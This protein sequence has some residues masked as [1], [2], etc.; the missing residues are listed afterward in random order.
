MKKFTHQHFRLGVFGFDGCHPEK[1]G[2]VVFTSYFRGV[3]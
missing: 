3:G 1:T 2:Q